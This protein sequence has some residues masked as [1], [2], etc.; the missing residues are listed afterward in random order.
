MVNKRTKIGIVAIVAV[1]ALVAVALIGSGGGGIISPHHTLTVMVYENIT[2]L[3]GASVSINGDIKITDDNGNAVYTLQEGE[4][5][6]VASKGE[7]Q[8]RSKTITLNKDTKVII[9]LVYLH[10]YLEITTPF[11]GQEINSKGHEVD[12]IRQ[13]L[14]EVQGKYHV[15]NQKINGLEVWI[16][17]SQYA[18]GSSPSL[19]WI[20]EVKMG[21]VKPGVNTVCVQGWTGSTKGS[22][23]NLVEEQTCDIVVPDYWVHTVDTVGKSSSDLVWRGNYYCKF[24]TIRGEIIRVKGNV[25]AEYFGNNPYVFW[26]NLWNECT[27]S[28]NTVDKNIGTSQGWS[29]VDSTIDSVRAMTV[30]FAGARY[31]SGEVYSRADEFRGEV[32]VRAGTIDCGI[33]D[34]LISL[35]NFDNWYTPPHVDV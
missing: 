11:G 1:F 3:P 14:F 31:A 4:Y 10:Q 18:W 23:G 24:R 28:W 2:P 22:K 17:D 15:G 26:L 6:I 32:W 12:A 33:L 5:E 29:P 13:V 7:Y 25:Y 35:F 27:D 20:V 21:R 16:G 19:S 8:T 30:S 9:D 34:G